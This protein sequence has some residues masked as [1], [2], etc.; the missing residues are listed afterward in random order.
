MKDSI[1]VDLGIIVEY[2]KT[3]KGVLPVAYEKYSMKITSVT[4]AELLASET[5]KDQ[6]LEQEVVEFVKKYFEVIV[7][8]EASGLEAAR[9]LRNNDVTLAVAMNAGTAKAESLQ[10]LTDNSKDYEKIEG[11]SLLKL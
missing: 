4:Y 3:G 11:V 7:V 6:K 2:L 9:V 8:T 1:L 5:F 10:L